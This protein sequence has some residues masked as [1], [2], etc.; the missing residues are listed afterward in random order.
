MWAQAEK[1]LV[2]LVDDLWRAPDGGRVAIP[3]FLEFSAA[4]MP[5]T[6]G[7]ASGKSSLIS[8]LLPFPAS[9][10]SFSFF[11]VLF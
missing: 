4:F 6:S 7:P 2:T 8:F 11:F 10:F 3:A 9:P 5:S 1:A